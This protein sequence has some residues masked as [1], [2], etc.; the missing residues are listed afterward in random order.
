VCF[1][2]RNTVAAAFLFFSFVLL[3]A[4]YS[5]LVP[6]VKGIHT[7]KKQKNAAAKRSKEE[8]KATFA[9]ELRAKHALCVYKN[10]CTFMYEYVCVC[11]CMCVVGVVET[12]RNNIFQNEEE[13]VEGKTK[14]NKKT[15]VHQPYPQGGSRR[16]ASPT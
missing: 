9:P 1:C 8:T 15:S 11:M 13:E 7:L 4:A 2:F 6:S 10:T 14:E 3:L 16:S 5:F 12:R